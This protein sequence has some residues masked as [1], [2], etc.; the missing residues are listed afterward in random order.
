MK[1]LLTGATGFVGHALEPVLTSHGHH[2]RCLTR[3][4]DK[5]RSKAPKL[6]WVAGSVDDPVTL[7]AATLHPEAT[8]L[9]DNADARMINHVLNRIGYG[10]IKAA[11]EALTRYMAVELGPRRISANAVAVR[12]QVSL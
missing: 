3:N 6:D 5:A 9:T 8:S 4:V 10:P 12:A 7:G 11:V 2:V 1:I